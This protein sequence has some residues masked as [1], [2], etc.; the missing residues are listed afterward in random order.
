M[1]KKILFSLL[2]VGVVGAMGIGATVAF[3]SDTEESVGNTFTAGEIDLTVDS[4]AHYDG[5][6]CVYDVTD[7]RYEWE[8][9]TT[10]SSTYPALIGTECAGSWSLTDLGPTHKFFDF[11]SGLEPGDEG[12]VT[13]SLHIVDDEAY[14]CAAFGNLQ[15][16]DLG[17]TEPEG[18]DG[19][20]S[21]GVG[22]GELAG[23]IYFFAWHDDGDN[24]WEDGE[25]VLFDSGAAETVLNDTVYAVANPTLGAIAGGVTKNIG[26]AWCYGTMTVDAGA[27]TITCD[28]S[29][30]GNS[31]QTDR[32]SADITFNVEQARNNSGFVC[33]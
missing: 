25:D 19:D 5:M 7:D 30:V 29:G 3:F 2:T 1:N 27:H 13:I 12:E 9:E 15:D 14:A 21:D 16:D 6:V 18:T 24:V 22:F 10:G 31:G 8:E 11:S 4:T 28:G 33:Q 20:S 23:Q 26:L 17:L 32:L